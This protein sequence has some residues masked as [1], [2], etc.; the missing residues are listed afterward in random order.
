MTDENEWDHVHAL[1]TLLSKK[2]ATGVLINLFPGPLRFT[3]VQREMSC[4]NSKT[5]TNT[6]KILEEEGLVRREIVDGRPPGV[7]YDLTASG[8]SLAERIYPLWKWSSDRA[9]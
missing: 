8:R 3:E 6:L 5:L 2:W 7:R 1:F 4:T 9:G